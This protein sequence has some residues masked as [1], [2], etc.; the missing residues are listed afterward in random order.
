MKKHTEAY[1]CI[2]ISSVTIDTLMGGLLV[3]VPRLVFALAHSM[4]T[5]PIVWIRALGHRAA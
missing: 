2:C 1:L 3:V 4:S 5:A